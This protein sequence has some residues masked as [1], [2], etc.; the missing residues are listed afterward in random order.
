MCPSASQFL[1]EV[2]ATASTIPELRDFVDTFW[3]LAPLVRDYPVPMK[4]GQRYRSN[5]IDPFAWVQTNLHE[6]LAK[7][8]SSFTSDRIDVSIKKQN[9]EAF[10][11]EAL[12]RADNP[13]R[14][15]FNRISKEHGFS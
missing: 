8:V 10:L 5:A 9:T 7:L 15:E 6:A 2:E 3:Q 12:R 14:A 4:S 1:A 13:R 11:Q